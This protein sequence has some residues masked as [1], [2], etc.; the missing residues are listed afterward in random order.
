MNAKGNRT[1]YLCINTPYRELV[2]DRIVELVRDLRVDGIFFD[3]FHANPVLSAALVTNITMVGYA[4]HL[5]KR[6]YRMDNRRGAATY[7]IR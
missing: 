1:S 6:K 3:M 7:S 2:R 4:L 5:L